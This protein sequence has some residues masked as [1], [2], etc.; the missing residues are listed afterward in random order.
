MKHTSIIATLLVAGLCAALPT[1]CKSDQ[2]AW[3]QAELK[4]QTDPA[5]LRGVKWVCVSI[6]TDAMTSAEPITLDFNAD[7]TVT[8]FS[9]INRFSAPYTAGTGSLTFGPIAATRMGGSAESMG[10]EQRF[11]QALAKTSQFSLQSG[12]LR[13]SDGGKK[14]LLEFSR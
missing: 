12:L 1:A 11:L 7:G 10:Q 3:V 14:K 2:P 5:S 4:E 8:G 9:G 6:D 13:L